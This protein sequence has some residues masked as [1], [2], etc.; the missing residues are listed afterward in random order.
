MCS[1]AFIRMIRRLVSS[2]FARCGIFSSHLYNN[3][4]LL[5]VI[6]C[7]S[8]P[9]LLINLFSLPHCRCVIVELST[10]PFNLVFFS[11]P[12]SFQMSS[13][14]YLAYVYNFSTP[15]NVMNSVLCRFYL[16]QGFLVI[17]DEMTR[18]QIHCDPST[19]HSMWTHHPKNDSGVPLCLISC[20]RG[21][22]P[23]FRPCAVCPLR[24]LIKLSFFGLLLGMP[25]RTLP[26]SD[27]IQIYDKTTRRFTFD[28]SFLLSLPTTVSQILPFVGFLVPYGNTVSTGNPTRPSIY[29][30][31]K[32][33]YH[34]TYDAVR[35][36]E[37]ISFICDVPLLK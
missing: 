15:A 24:H 21:A 35:Y 8:F 3:P 23:C 4:F 14:S 28:L 18:L 11:F 19:L 13:D 7:I 26:T 36:R 17:N 2:R 1:Y 29:V 31:R 32:F 16:Q 5:Y 20:I 25:V 33:L 12:L 30:P 37:L 22:A 27:E 10:P 34:P 6:R 9:I